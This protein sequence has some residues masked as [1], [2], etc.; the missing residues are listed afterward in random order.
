MPEFEVERHTGESAARAWDR[1]TD[2]ERHGEFIPFTKVWL[3]SSGAAPA[4]RDEGFVAR[5]SFGPFH[6]DDPMDITYWQPPNGAEPGICRIV[7]RGR[8]VTGWAV[9]TVTPTTTGCAIAWRENAAVRFTG[10]VL[11][12]P[13]RVIAARVFGRLVDGLLR[14]H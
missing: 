5:T 2:W 7:K 1:L 4:G 11:A 12:W 9:L 3:T 13:T 6:F 10:T 14:A 8:V